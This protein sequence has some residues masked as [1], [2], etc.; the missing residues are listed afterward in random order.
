MA[1][2]FGGALDNRQ[3]IVKPAGVTILT[4]AD[5]KAAIFGIFANSM[6]SGVDDIPSAVVSAA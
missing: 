2:A 4:N 5:K 1:M 3:G 6:S